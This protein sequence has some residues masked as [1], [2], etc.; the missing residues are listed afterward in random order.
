MEDV[1]RA[2]GGLPEVGDGIVARTCV[3]I[4]RK[5]WSPPDLSRAAGTSKYR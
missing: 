3:Q 4:Q 1:A 5:Y 2:L